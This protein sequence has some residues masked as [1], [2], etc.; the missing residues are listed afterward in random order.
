VERGEPDPPT[1][2]VVVPRRPRVRPLDPRAPRQPQRPAGAEVE[3]QQRRL[4][5]C[6]QVAEAVEHV[7][8]VVVGPPEVVAVHAHE[9]RRS[10]A[11]R[12]VDTAGGVG[13]AQEDRVRATHEVGV[14]VGAPPRRA[15]RRGDVALLDELRAVAVRLVDLEE[16]AGERAVDPQPPPGGEVDGHQSHLLPV[17]HPGQRVP[18]GQRGADAQ[19]RALHPQEARRGEQGGGPQPAVPVAGREDGQVAVGEEARREVR[20]AQHPGE[21]SGQVT[22]PGALLDGQ[23]AFVEAAH[24]A[25][26]MVEVYF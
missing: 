12:R 11:V 5:V 23:F 16:V 15:R 24:R 2:V 7:V 20:G 6:G 19:A 18:G 3:D 17:G 25:L 8:A 21:P 1:G 9:P 14:E 10:A 13:G 26:L 4:V 22:D